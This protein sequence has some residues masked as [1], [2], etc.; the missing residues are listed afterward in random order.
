MHGFSFGE[1]PPVRL[2]VD[3]ELAFVM[4]RY[5]E[6]H[7]LLHTVYGI[8]VS[9]GGE[10]ALKWFEMVQTLG[11]FLIGTVAQRVSVSFF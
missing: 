1:R 5:R 2:I 11:P 3:P 6:T 8:P 7:D 4:Q 9:V 10:V